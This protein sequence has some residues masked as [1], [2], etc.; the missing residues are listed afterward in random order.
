MIL[1]DKMPRNAH[2]LTKL[3]NKK[4]KTKP[5]QQK[6]PPKLKQ[7]FFNVNYKD[8]SAAY[9][10]N[11]QNLLLS[12]NFN[13]I[14]N[15]WYLPHELK[16]LCD[17]Q[18]EVLTKDGNVNDRMLDPYEPRFRMLIGSAKSISDDLEKK[19]IDADLPRVHISG[20][21]WHEGAGIAP[22]LVQF[23][24]KEFADT[25][26]DSINKVMN[27]DKVLHLIIFGRTIKAETSTRSS[28]FIYEDVI[29][30]AS[31]FLLNPIS[32]IL[33]WIAVSSAQYDDATWNSEYCPKCFNKS[34]KLGSL[35]IAIIQQL[36]NALQQHTKICCQVQQN[37]DAGPLLFYL[38]NGFQFIGDVDDDD[39]FVK[40]FL[41]TD[42]ILLMVVIL[43]GWEF[44]VL[45]INSILGGRT[46]R[47]TP[48]K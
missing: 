47:N 17:A 37:P 15:I 20:F 4:A 6:H 30:A 42:I 27:D 33:L 31:S 48:I 3:K 19:S 46:I 25:E 14:S 18:V 21:E 28:R 2:Q 43:F 22:A 12:I 16:I 39:T 7:N 40:S 45:S 10:N 41:T 34:F 11:P 1:L 23:Y 32:N 38:K 24:N 29:V 44:L 26:K 8:L 13:Q 5:A 36:S 9:A 35:M